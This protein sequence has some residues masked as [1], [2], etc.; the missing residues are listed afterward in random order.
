MLFFTCTSI[1]PRG[2]DGV[3]AICYYTFYGMTKCCAGSYCVLL[4][5]LNSR[6]VDNT[7]VTFLSSFYNS[8]D[9]SALA[10]PTMNTKFSP[11]TCD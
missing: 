4:H 2:T 7:S 1:K 11:Q 6:K 8:S 5:I 3:T 10:L 9:S